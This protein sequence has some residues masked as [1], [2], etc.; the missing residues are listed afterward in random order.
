M[1]DSVAWLDIFGMYIK[2]E[3]FQ[4]TDN[5]YYTVEQ[6]IVREP[7][8]TFFV[9]ECRKGPTISVFD[10]GKRISEKSKNLLKT[11]NI[12]STF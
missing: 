10:F 11:Y 12:V 6:F 4:R 5:Y 3:N 8:Y 7:L 9:V 1:P 2:I